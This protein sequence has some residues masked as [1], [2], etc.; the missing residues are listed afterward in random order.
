MHITEAKSII[1]DE[2]SSLQYTP[3]QQ[4]NKNDYTIAADVKRGA[5]V[6][7]FHSDIAKENFSMI[8]ETLRNHLTLRGKISPCSG[9]QIEV[10]NH[11]W[12]TVSDAKENTPSTEASPPICTIM[13]AKSRFVDILRIKGYRQHV[14]NTTNNRGE[15]CIEVRDKSIFITSHSSRFKNNMLVVFR[16]LYMDKE[17]GCE[18]HKEMKDSVMVFSNPKWTVVPSKNAELPSAQKEPPHPN[19]TE[20]SLFSFTERMEKIATRLEACVQKSEQETESSIRTML[21]IVFKKMCATGMLANGITREIFV[22]IGFLSIMS[23]RA[24]RV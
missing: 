23:A 14:G 7:E 2:M 8:V 17:L 6:I 20:E 21:G 16:D 15:Y 3:S 10:T 12:K 24:S 5:I 18:N 19:M 9:S 4:D 22:E 13:E 1:V 11:L